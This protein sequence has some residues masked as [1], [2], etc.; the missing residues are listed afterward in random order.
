MSQEN[1]DK[2]LSRIKSLSL[3]AQIPADT[4]LKN[5]IA[6]QKRLE[7]ELTSPNLRDVLFFNFR[8]TV[9]AIMEKSGIFYQGQLKSRKDKGGMGFSIYPIKDLELFVLLLAALIEGETNTSLSAFL[10]EEFNQNLDQLAQI[11][12]K[13]AIAV[14]NYGKKRAKATIFNIRQEMEKLKKEM[15]GK[16]PYS[17]LFTLGSDIVDGMLLIFKMEVPEANPYTVAKAINQVLS[18]FDKTA[19]VPAILQRIKRTSQ[20]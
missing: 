8:N 14:E 19:E 9:I 2:L 16:L 17:S 1:F 7:S 6:Y 13:V 5:S 12:D 20:K 11:L 18:I 10:V 15:Q 3:P 4:R